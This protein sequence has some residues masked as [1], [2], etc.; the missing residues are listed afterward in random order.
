MTDSYAASSI[1]SWKDW[2]GL[3]A[4]IIPGIVFV[5][6]GAVKIV[7][8]E[9]FRANILAY[10]LVGWDVAHIL[11]IVLPVVEIAA[12][13]LLLGGL[14]TR[15][16][17]AAIFVMLLMF[18]GGIAWVWSQGINIDCGC[19]GTGGEVDASQTQYPLKMAENLGMATLCGWLMLRPQ[20]LFSLDRALFGTPT[21]SMTESTSASDA[22]EKE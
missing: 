20:S 14:F 4:R 10:Q 12:G 9:G 7:D 11:S 16:A 21:R 17:A 2:V 3:I 22:D 19:F 13:L 1:R 15:W 6:A 5:W 8:M 18:M